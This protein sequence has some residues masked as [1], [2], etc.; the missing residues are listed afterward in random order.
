MFTKEKGEKHSKTC[1]A[2]KRLHLPEGESC[3]VQHIKSYVCNSLRCPAHI[4][5]KSSKSR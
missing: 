5:R 3:F 4:K 1:P 2:L